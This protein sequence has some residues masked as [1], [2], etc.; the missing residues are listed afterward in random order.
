MMTD[1]LDK[2]APLLM[3]GVP[4]VVVRALLLFSLLF[5]CRSHSRCSCPISTCPAALPRLDLFLPFLHITDYPPSP[6][7]TN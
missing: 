4:L 5:L 2:R 3:L 7:C 6:P 1:Q